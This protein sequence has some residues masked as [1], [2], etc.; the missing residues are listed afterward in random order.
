MT[1]VL[2]LLRT[3]HRHYVR[4]RVPATDPAAAQAQAAAW[5]DE[6]KQAAI[7]YAHRPDPGVGITFLTVVELAPG[8]P[9]D[10]DLTGV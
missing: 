6:H 5:C 3:R 2:C 8:G 1:T 10:V 7:R 9:V 4:I